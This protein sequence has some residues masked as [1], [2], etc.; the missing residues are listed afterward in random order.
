M[1]S[2]NL[3]KNKKASTGEAAGLTWGEIA[4][5]IL[6]LALVAFAFFWFSSWGSKLYTILKGAFK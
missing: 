3:A 5:W 1:K 6:L 4:R 2:I